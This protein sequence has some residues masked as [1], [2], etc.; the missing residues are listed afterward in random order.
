VLIGA[1]PYARFGD[2]FV[3]L[4]FALTA[5][6]TLATWADGWLASRRQPK[7]NPLSAAQKP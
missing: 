4:M 3:L 6:W 2:A 7:S 5:V 1:T